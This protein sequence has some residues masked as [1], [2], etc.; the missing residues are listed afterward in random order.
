MQIAGFGQT[1]KQSAQE[2]SALW[3]HLGD[4]ECA[5]QIEVHMES[6]GFS[7]DEIDAELDDLGLY[8]GRIYEL[9]ILPPA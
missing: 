9:V 1:A 7:D 4:D 5:E 3:K 6:D 8:D 2:L